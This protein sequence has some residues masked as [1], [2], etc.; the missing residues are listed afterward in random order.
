[1]SL[2]ISLVTSIILVVAAPLLPLLFGHEYVSLPGFVRIMAFVIV[3]MSMYATALEALGSSGHQLQRAL[4]LNSAAIVGGGT[5]A[6][7]TWLLGLNGTFA[8]GYAVEAGTAAFAWHILLR[9]AAASELSALP[10]G[11]AGLVRS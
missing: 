10:V 1:V 6:L 5:V 8:A 7:A 3:F 2:G 4:V 11:Q 9:L